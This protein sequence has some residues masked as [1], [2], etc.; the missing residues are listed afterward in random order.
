MLIC[1]SISGSICRFR[2]RHANALEI[3]TWMNWLLYF[4]GGL[5]NMLRIISRA[6]FSISSSCVSLLFTWAMSTHSAPIVSKMAKMTR[7][8]VLSVR[9]SR[10]KGS[11]PFSSRIWFWYEASSRTSAIMHLQPTNWSFSDLD[12]SMLI[13]WE[14]PIFWAMDLRWG[15]SVPANVHSVM[16]ACSRTTIDQSSMLDL[17]FTLFEKHLERLLKFK[18]W[19]SIIKS[20]VSWFF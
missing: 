1:S 5:F 13:I 3:S 15:L 19:N 17:I 12:I 9:R 2:I 20:L 7:L 18:A 16:A 4:G 6:P 10:I 14:M 11:M 8:L